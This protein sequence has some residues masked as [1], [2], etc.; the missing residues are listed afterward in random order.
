MLGQ[1]KPIRKMPG[2]ASNN[3]GHIIANLERNRPH[4]GS[5]HYTS[6]VAQ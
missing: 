6:A 3:F 1:Q 5:I 2:V 4:N